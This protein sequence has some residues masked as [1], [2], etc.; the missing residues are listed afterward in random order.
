MH[1]Q[2]LFLVVYAEISG[3]SNSMNYSGCPSRHSNDATRTLARASILIVLL[4]VHGIEGA[5]LEVELAKINGMYDF[6]TLGALITH[7]ALHSG[8][9]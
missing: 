7:L 8:Y 9:Q 4:E 5:L 3:K 6:R 2:K 1:L